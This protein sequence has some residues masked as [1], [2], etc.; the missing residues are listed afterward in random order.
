MDTYHRDFNL[1]NTT[2]G[3]YGPSEHAL[4][5]ALAAINRT[6]N[7]SQKLPR[8]LESPD[9]FEDFVFYMNRYGMP[10]I[11]F[12]GIIGNITCLAVFLGTHLRFLNCYLYLAFLNMADTLFL[13]CLLITWLGWWEVYLFH[14]N[15]WCQLVIYMSYVSSFWSTWSVA[16][17]TGERF[18]VVYFPMKQQILCTRTKAFGILGFLTIFALAS[19]SFA[20]VI[21]G[22]VHNPTFGTV[23]MTFAEY[24]DFARAATAVDT[25]LT[26]LVPAA[27]ISALNFAIMVK[28]WK[29]FFQINNSEHSLSHAYSFHSSSTAGSLIS[30]R[31]SNIRYNN[32]KRLHI[33]TTKSL[34]TVSSV[35]LLLNLPYHS[36]RIHM[37]I[38]FLVH[39][40]TP[41]TDSLQR[42]Q[43][44]LQFLSYLNYSANFFLY[45]ACS[46]SFT[47][48]LRRMVLKWRHSLLKLWNAYR[49]LSN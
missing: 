25:F 48:A 35:F 32:R 23:C 7:Y 29:F 20:L 41:Y 14:Q 9:S 33:Q 13:C 22:I 8:T 30:S 19:Y 36:L 49:A 46:R 15:G 2:M 38:H 47:R 11:I 21:N 17:F 44:I 39:T 5:L 37:M 4:E 40:D 42:V 1:S 12:G 26:L 31:N 16:I 27:I 43:Q 28:I 3:S 34:L 6:L 45:S 18:V 10:I 24:D